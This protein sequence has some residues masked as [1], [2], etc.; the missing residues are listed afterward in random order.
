MSSYTIFANFSASKSDL[1][2][3]LM[4]MEEQPQDS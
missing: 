1:K 2:A 3:P 4:P